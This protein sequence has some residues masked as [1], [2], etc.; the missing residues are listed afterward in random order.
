[1]I[2]VIA[3]TPSAQPD[4]ILEFKPEHERLGVQYRF[5]NGW[6]TQFNGK[7]TPLNK[8][9]LMIEW[10]KYEQE[11]SFMTVIY[12]NPS[13]DYYTYN[14]LFYLNTVNQTG[15]TSGVFVVHFYK[16]NGFPLGSIDI[17]GN[18]FIRDI[19]GVKRAYTDILKPR[20]VKWWVGEFE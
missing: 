5:D 7:I 19:E 1:M 2:G 15:K 14:L 12:H 3:I 10:F 4:E 9:A 6:A 16:Q 13:A 18:V 11:S 20:L 8:S 17:E